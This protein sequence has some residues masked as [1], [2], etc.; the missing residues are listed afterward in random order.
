MT[1]EFLDPVL[2]WI[3]RLTIAALFAAAGLSKLLQPVAF[4]EAVAAYDLV[5]GRAVAP[6]AATL[7]AAE[8]L[9]AALLLWPAG[10]VVGAVLLGAMLLA[11]SAAIAISIGLMVAGLFEFNLGD[12]EIMM[13]YLFLIAA[14]FAWTRLEPTEQHRGDA[15]PG[16]VVL[17]QAS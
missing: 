13:P 17:P 2:V 8:V 14:G 6:V 11:F 15:V 12:S 16:S 7:A 10:R 3:A 5:P 4:R 1:M 9:G